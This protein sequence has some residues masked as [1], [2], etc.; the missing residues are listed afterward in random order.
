MCF[1]AFVYRTVAMGSCPR[2][3]LSS[4]R[5]MACGGGA[6]GGRGGTPPPSPHRISRLS[7]SRLTSHLV[8]FVGG[9]AAAAGLS[10]R[11][12][13]AAPFDRPPRSSLIPW[14]WRCPSLGVTHSFH[15][16]GDASRLGWGIHRHMLLLL[17]P[18]ACPPAAWHSRR[19]S[20]PAAAACGA[21]MTHGAGRWRSRGAMGTNHAYQ[22]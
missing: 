7:G 14:A 6:A 2:L 4:A 17:L 11:G 10:L 19:H 9:G 5:D 3:A 21:P 8:A 22:S 16:F 20:R 13:P 18:A 12:A 1:S 15:G